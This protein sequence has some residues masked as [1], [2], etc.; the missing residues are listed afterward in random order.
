MQRVHLIIIK[1][2]DEELHYIQ[3]LNKKLEKTDQ[4]TFLHL[5]SLLFYLIFKAFFVELL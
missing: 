1:S 4:A 2:S 5:F 3:L